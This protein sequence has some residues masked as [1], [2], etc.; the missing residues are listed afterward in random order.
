[1]ET[2][3]LDGRKASEEIRAK[4][5][6][7]VKKLEE[8][9]KV[10]KLV[11]VTVGEDPASKSYVKAKE[12]AGSKIGILT[13]NIEFPRDI[14][15]QELVEK[16]DELNQ[17]DDVDGIVVQL[18]LPKSIDKE[19]VLKTI[20]IDKDVDC[21]NPLNL[22][23]LMIA[24]PS[25]YP[26][27]PMGIIELLSF[28]N[29]KIEGSYVVILGRGKTVGLPLANILLKKHRYGN[30]TV[31]VCHTKTRD[32]KSVSRNADILIAA[33]GSPEFIKEDF[34]KEGCV[35][36]DAGINSVEGKIVGDVDKNSVMGKAGALSPVPGG[37]GPMTVTMLFVIE[38]AKRN[39]A[40]KDV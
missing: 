10:P 34:I 27:T 12:R 24:E 38:A 25:F 5:V 4:L 17:R 23:Y 36:V 2:L 6:E 3:I 11:F 39:V 29:I 22:G 9:G 1:M 28:Y 20:Y 18:P 14:S 37:V 30:A 19:R 21:L 7:E 33:M 35:V 16:I 8:K 26:N 15:T 13:E 40:F 31:T 32:I